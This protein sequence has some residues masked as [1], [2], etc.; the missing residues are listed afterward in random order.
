MVRIV[1]GSKARLAFV[2]LLDTFLRAH[3]NGGGVQARAPE[4]GGSLLEGL[5][6]YIIWVDIDLVAS[7]NMMSLYMGAMGA[8][9]PA[10]RTGGLECILG[11][12]LGTFGKPPHVT[13]PAIALGESATMS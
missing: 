4:L 2:R 13:D 3:C 7:E 1:L 10:L 9:S 6:R 12:L 5:S 8:P 11:K